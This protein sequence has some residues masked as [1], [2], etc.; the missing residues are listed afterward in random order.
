MQSR[1]IIAHEK[2]TYVLDLFYVFL[3]ISFLLLSFIRVIFSEK[4]LLKSPSF[5]AIVQCIKTI[6]AL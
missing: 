3:L 6:N 2:R 4:N 1:N 5:F